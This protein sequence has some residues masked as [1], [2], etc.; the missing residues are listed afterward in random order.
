M[1]KLVSRRNIDFLL[2]DWLRLDDLLE[3]PLYEDHDRDTVTSVID[4]GAQIAEEQFAP[5]NQLLD[6]QEP[7]MADDGTVLHPDGLK[8]ALAAYTASGL[9]SAAFPPALGGMLLPFS[10]VQAVFVHLHAASMGASGY[11]MLGAG[12]AALLYAYGSPEQITRYALPV[13]EGRWYGT[14]CLSEP[15]VGSS[16]GDLTT[17]A[18]PQDDGT[19]RVFGTKMWISG[20]DQSLSDNI[21][22]LVLARTPDGP[23][24]VKGLSLFVVPKVLVEPDG[25]LGERNDVTLVGLNHKMG[26]RGTT[27]TLLSFGEGGWTPGGAPGAVGELI[28]E[29]GQG[30]AAMFHMMNEARIGVGLGA[31][32][33][34]NT[35][36]LHSLAYARERT[37]GRPL[38]D[39]DPQSPMVSIIEHPDV[40][41][42]LLAQKAYA[43]GGLALSL[44][45]A[46]LVDEQRS[47]DE[48]AK[49]RA[50]E[51]LEMLTPIAKSWPSQW[52]LEGNAMAIQVLGGYGYTRDYPVEQFY[53]DNRL[54]PIH[55]GTVGIQGLDLLGRKVTAHGGAGLALLLATMHET[56]ERARAAGGEAATYAEQLAL[57][58]GRIADVTAALWADRDADV[59]LANATLYLEAVGHTVV[60]WLWLDQLLAV[61]G[62]D[63]F[64]RGKQ[65]AV[66]YFYGYEL[67]KTAATF[68]LLGSKDRTTLDLDPA[69]LG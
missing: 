67:P 35:G 50:T 56:V 64:A 59:A 38:T 30:L 52:C 18:V 25:S 20:G 60:A 3:R 14:M 5:I 51:L 8:Q 4:L 40:R 6:A 15:D 10:V 16:L 26:C 37:Q 13:V 17:R 39:R 46:R 48:A 43:E 57:S 62:D 63:A 2:F 21:I 45:C 66:R 41:R 23:A 34:G 42:M 24:G 65:A 32:A 31:V 1:S 28:G 61:S 69:D 7:T 47:G 53:R 33:L 44:Y 12:N 36:Y 55:E 29:V 54:N 11:P 19:W 9:P 22:H 27:N 49:L 68:D 58:M